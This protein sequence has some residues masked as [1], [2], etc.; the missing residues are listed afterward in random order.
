MKWIKFFF[1]V[2]EINWQEAKRIMDEN[3]DKYMLIDVRQPEEYKET[4][5]KGSELI[6]L[7]QLG[8]SLNKLIKDG[9]ILL[10]CRSGSRSRL[11]ARILKSKG[12]DNVLNIKGGILQYNK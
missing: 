4:N 5:V 3:P 9:H 6:P 7:F 11:G 12:F 8:K 10:Y 1:P 2:K